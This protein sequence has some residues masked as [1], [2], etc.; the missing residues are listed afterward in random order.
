[1]NQVHYQPGQADQFYHRYEYDAENRITDVYTTNNKALIGDINLEEHD[2][3]Y[4]YYKHG[5]LARTVLGQQQVQGIDYAYTL[6]SW[7]K[8]VNSSSLNPVYDMGEDGKQEA[9][10]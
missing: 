3:H 7:L 10:F 5:P 2:A 8:G 4:E 6:Q 9:S 1:L